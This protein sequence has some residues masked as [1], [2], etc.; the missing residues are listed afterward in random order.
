M[1]YLYLILTLADGS[2]II[3][4]KGAAGATW[5]DCIKYASYVLYQ[6]RYP[7]AYQVVARETSCRR[8]P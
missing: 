1:F 5:D 8:Q 4:P 3:E 2:R 7:R 6:E